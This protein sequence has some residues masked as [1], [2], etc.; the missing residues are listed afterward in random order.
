MTEDWARQFRCVVRIQS[1]ILI[2][3]SRFQ[4]TK[5]NSSSFYNYPTN[6]D[7]NASIKLIFDTRQQGANTERVD[8][9]R[10]NKV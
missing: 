9:E 7:K 2:F 8:K 1:N 10:P 4:T 3:I 5:I 6:I